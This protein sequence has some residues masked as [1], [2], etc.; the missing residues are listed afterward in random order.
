MFDFTSLLLPGRSP[1]RRGGCRRAGTGTALCRL[2]SVPDPRTRAGAWGFPSRSGADRG[3]LHLEQEL[4]VALG[5]L[6]PLHEHFQRLLWL[7][8]V[9]HPAEL[10]DDLQLFGGHQQVFLAGAGGVHVHGGEDPLV[11]ELTAQPQLHVAGPLELLEDH[12]VRA[13]AG[14]DQGGGQDR[15]RAA[16]LDVARRA[17]EP[18]RRVEGGRVHTAGHDPPAGRRGQVVGAAEPGDR[19]EQDD[20]VVAHLGQALG[21]FDGQLRHRG[22]V[23][24]RPVEGRVDDLALDRALHIGDLL[25]P[26]VHEHD[27][28][29]AF[30][31]VLGD[32]V[33]DGLQDQRLAR[34]RRRHDEAT[35]ALADGRDQVDDP[36]RHVARIGLQPQPLLRVQ[37]HQLGEL[38][39]GPGLLRVKPVDLVEPDQRV[40]LL[41]PLALAWLADRALDDVSLA[42]AVLAHLRQRDVHVVGPRQVTGGADERVVVEHIEDA[43][44]RDEDVVLGDHGLGVA[45]ALAAP[46]VAVAEP[47]PVAAPAAV[48]GVVVAAAALVLLARL[49][50]TLAALVL[51][52]LGGLATARLVVTPAVVA[53]PPVTTLAVATL[54]AVRALG[55]AVLGIPALLIAGRARGTCPGRAGGSGRGVRGR[56]PAGRPR[57][58]EGQLAVGAA[59]AGSI[60]P[61]LAR[62]CFQAGSRWIGALPQALL[63][64]SV[65]FHIVLLT[66]ARR[67]GSRGRDPLG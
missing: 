30:G 55:I 21:S 63:I 22:V 33:G 44:D 29:V 38:R 53:P 62:W 18:L 17:E 6:H 37:R 39:P 57:V 5:A 7:E 24:G 23:L 11:G 56:S 48:I 32:R 14:L 41:P 34:L 10:P 13:G 46:P 3:L 4:S 15:D 42:Q 45:A 61:R 35:L 47:V 12:L 58:L 59:T 52:L 36:R 51:A 9:Q 28:E 49:A 64:G 2:T 50:T 43:G 8:R 66:V 25:G 19:V 26:L 65:W 40:E 1:G 20:H 60:L 54:V 16:M 27:H 31:V 67:V